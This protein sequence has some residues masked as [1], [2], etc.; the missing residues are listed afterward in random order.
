MTAYTEPVQTAPTQSQHSAASADPGT[1]DP[2]WT[3]PEDPAKTG[4]PAR[5]ARKPIPAAALF[6]CILIALALLVG[7]DARTGGFKKRTDLLKTTPPGTLITSG[8]YEFRFTEATAQHKKDFGGAPYW[9]VVIIGEGRTTGTE[10]SSPQVFLFG[11]RQH[12]HN[13]NNKQVVC[14]E[15]QSMHTARHDIIHTGRCHSARTRSS[16]FT[17]TTIG[18]ARPFTSSADWSMEH[19]FTQQQ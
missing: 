4:A 12:V 19:G 13:K 18:L 7:W 17:P 6:G 8:P 14:R 5:I 16:S 15:Q 3:P 11:R 1:V 9:E 2:N 10:S